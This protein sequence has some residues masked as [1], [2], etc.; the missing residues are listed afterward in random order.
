MENSDLRTR[1]MKGYNNITTYKHEEGRV[2]V[3]NN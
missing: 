3:L 2:I 1:D